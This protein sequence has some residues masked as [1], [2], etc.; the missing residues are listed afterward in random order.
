M[1]SLS[2]G[3]IQTPTTSTGFKLHIKG[4]VQQNI[5]CKVIKIS[6]V[7]IRERQNNLLKGNYY[8]INFN[9]YN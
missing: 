1:I 5:S 3:D 4:S 6:A 8:G 9:D 2:F 7:D